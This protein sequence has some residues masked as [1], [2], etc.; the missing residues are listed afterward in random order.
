MIV[1]NSMSLIPSPAGTG[2]DQGEKVPA[3]RA[4]HRRRTGLAVFAGV[5]LAL[6]TMAMTAAPAA[7]VTSNAGIYAITPQWGGWCPKG[8]GVA[9]Y[10]KVTHVR[11]V[12]HTTGDQW[13]DSGDDIVW[14]RVRLN[15][16]NSITMAV[17]CR[18]SMP[19]G[20]NFTIRPTRNGQS[21]WFSAVGGHSRN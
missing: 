10:N 14:A 2:S 16:N 1:E 12:N 17:Q 3:T 6:T 7:A 15:Q 13:G 8:T 4:S 9:R 18:W 21:F 5:L 11:Y 19:Q 20:T